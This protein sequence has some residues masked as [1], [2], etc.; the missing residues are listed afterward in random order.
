MV[1]ADTPSIMETKAVN[2]G[3]QEAGQNEQSQH[4]QSRLQTR[5]VNDKDFLTF[6][7]RYRRHQL[8]KQQKR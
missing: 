8:T 2:G 1:F 3:H 4:G 5:Y 6:F 7:Y